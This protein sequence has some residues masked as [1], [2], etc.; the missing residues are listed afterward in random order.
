M[1]APSKVVKTQLVKI[2]HEQALTRQSLQKRASME[3][4]K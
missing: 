4:T 3:V 1:S 2:Q